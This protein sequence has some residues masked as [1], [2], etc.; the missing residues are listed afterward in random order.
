[1]SQQVVLGRYRHCKYSRLK[2]RPPITVFRQTCLAEGMSFTRTNTGRACT[3][4]HQTLAS[5]A[6]SFSHPSM[7]FNDFAPTDPRP[8]PRAKMQLIPP[9][10][11]TALWPPLLILILSL[12]SCLSRCLFFPLIDLASKKNDNMAF[13]ESPSRLLRT[14]YI[15]GRDC[16]SAFVLH[17]RLGLLEYLLIFFPLPFLQLIFLVIYRFFGFLIIRT[18]PYCTT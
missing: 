15:P 9:L 4:T 13:C 1:M 18:P 10:C 16:V 2:V 7:D 6:Q 17:I 8:S 14:E 5:T 12:F 3:C 11:L